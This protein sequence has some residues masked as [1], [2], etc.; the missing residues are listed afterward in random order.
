MRRT[1]IF[2]EREDGDRQ[3]VALTVVALL[4]A[5]CLVAPATEADALT[6]SDQVAIATLRLAVR[7]R[8]ATHIDLVERMERNAICPNLIMWPPPIVLFS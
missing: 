5:V 8:L 7:N 6:A 1:L 2:R 4:V 3:L